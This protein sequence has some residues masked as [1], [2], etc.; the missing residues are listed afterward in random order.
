MSRFRAEF[1]LAI[2]VQKL[3]RE[4]RDLH[5]T[6]EVV[7]EITAKFRERALLILLY[8][9]DEEMEKRRYHD[10]LRDDIREFVNFYCFKSL[11]DMISRA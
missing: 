11:E 2:L 3:A 6:I 8:V 4:F 1:A 9:A 5:Q 7:A 10:M